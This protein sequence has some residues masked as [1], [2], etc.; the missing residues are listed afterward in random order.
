MVSINNGLQVDLTGQI[1]SETQFGTRMING[2]GGQTEMH[3]GAFLARGGRAIT[4]LSS[5]ALGGMSTI[6]PYFEHGSLV[7]IPRHFAD[8]IITE[9]GIARLLDKT[10]KERAEELINVAHPDHREYLKEQA[11]ELFSP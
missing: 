6:V 11:R 7:T 1:C 8:T 4:L 2:Q 3:L 5:T 9:Y 10:H